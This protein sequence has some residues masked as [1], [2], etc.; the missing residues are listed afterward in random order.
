MRN[1]TTIQQF[2]SLQKDILSEYAQKWNGKK[3]KTTF[4]SAVKN[5]YGFEKDFGWNI[6]LNSFYVIDDTELAKIS[7]KQFE[8]QGPSRHSDIGE[9]YLRLYG[10]L[11]AIYQQKLAIDNLLEVHKIVN[12]KKL[13]KQ[14]SE[15]KIIELRNKIGAHSTNYKSE[16]IESEHNFDVYEISRPKLDRDVISLLRN[17]NEFEKYDL[18][19]DVEIFDKMIESNLSIITTKIIKKVYQNQGD[20]FK[21]LTYI[22]IIR[23]EGKDLGKTIIEFN[24]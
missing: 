23:N 10:L 15:S 5:F 18:L 12:K 2:N 24:K 16:R 8:L 1:E 19:K 21:R 20:F 13:S 7:F 6:L 17:Q 11:N 3:N 14:L 9:R 4:R 22:E